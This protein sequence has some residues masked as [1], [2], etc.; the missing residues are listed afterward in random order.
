L[1]SLSIPKKKI[2]IDGD[3]VAAQVDN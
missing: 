1:K 2:C 3:D